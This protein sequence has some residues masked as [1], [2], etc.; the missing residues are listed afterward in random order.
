MREGSIRISFLFY[1]LESNLLYILNHWRYKEIS[2]L[3][4]SIYNE[5]KKRAVPRNWKKIKNNSDNKQKSAIIWIFQDVAT[6]FPG[7]IIFKFCFSYILKYT[8]AMW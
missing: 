1:K 6:K 4:L 8:D 3:W 2:I 7:S 5:M